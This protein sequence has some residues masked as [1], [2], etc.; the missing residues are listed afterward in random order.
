MVQDRTEECAGPGCLSA[1]LSEQEKGK[2]VLFH[3]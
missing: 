1:T 2:G 3:G